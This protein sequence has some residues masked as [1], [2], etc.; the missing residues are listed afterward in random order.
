MQ[1][2][3]ATFRETKKA[4]AFEGVIVTSDKAF[5]ET[6]GYVPGEPLPLELQKF[7]AD[8]YAFLKRQIGYHGTD[9]NILSAAVH[10]DETTPHLQLYY[11]PVV[12]EGRKKV[13]AKGADDKVL[14]NEKG[15]P[16]QEKDKNG[17]SLYERVLLEQPKICSSEFWEQRGAQSS[18]GNLQDEF[19]EQVAP[20][21]CRTNSMSRWRG[22][23][24][25]SAAK[26][27]AAKSTR[28]NINGRSSS[29]NKSW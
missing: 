17:K 3:N 19:H 26:S 21:I 22:I 18:F 4:V 24:A 12:D 27:A 13:Y 5:F 29:K 15:S 25:W 23:T 16:V 1:D 14:R 9:R 20:G 6:R 11:I 10:L 7:F 8:S 28:P 2:L